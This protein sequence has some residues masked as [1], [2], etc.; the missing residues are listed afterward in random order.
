RLSRRERNYRRPSR[1]RLPAGETTTTTCRYV[2][3]AYRP[4]PPF[5]VSVSTDDCQD[6]CNGESRGGLSRLF[7]IYDGSHH[8]NPHPERI[9]LMTAAFAEMIVLIAALLIVEAEPELF[10]VLGEWDLE[11]LAGRQGLLDA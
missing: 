9:K 2:S 4:R 3:S 10:F 5:S 7:L 8:F 6:A 1:R 11:G